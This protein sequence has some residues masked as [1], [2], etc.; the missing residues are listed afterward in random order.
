[1]AS[2]IKWA[3]GMPSFGAIPTGDK[4]GLNKEEGNKGGKGRK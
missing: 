1:M 3:I 4:V 2:A